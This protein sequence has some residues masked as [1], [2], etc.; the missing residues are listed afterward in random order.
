M[1]ITFIVECDVCHAKYVFKCQCDHVMNHGSMPIRVG[2]KNC[3]NMLSGEVSLQSLI[4][5][6]GIKHNR[7]NFVEDY[8]CVGVSTELPICADCYFTNGQLLTNYMCLPGYVKTENLSAHS[9]RVSKL[10]DGMSKTLEDIKTLY[11]IYCNGN[12]SVFSAYAEEMFG[13]DKNEPIKDKAD[14]RRGLV[15]IFMQLFGVIV[16][17]A[18]CLRFTEPFVNELDS[19]VA[20]ADANT[21]KDLLSTVAAKMNVEGDIDE[22]LKVL[23]GFIGKIAHFFPVMLLLDEGDFSNPYGG[24]LFLSTTDYSEIKNLYAELFELL[25]RWSMLLVGLENLKMRGDYDKLSTTKPLSD[26]CNMSNGKKSEYISANCWLKDYYLQ[27]LD[28]KI[29]N[30]IDHAKAKY[31]TITQILEYCPNINKPN[32]KQKIALIDFIFIILQQAIKLAESL[33]LVMKMQTRV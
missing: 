13:K 21:L 32:E 27:T 24:K 14:M 11:N 31:N 7:E 16:S 10:A 5:T 29:R 15:N 9:R 2:C 23:M 12:I 33:Y 20:N 6:K 22:S 25:S 4:I 17:K 8:P 26:F 18:Y 28:N 19:I 3:G 1:T 30:G